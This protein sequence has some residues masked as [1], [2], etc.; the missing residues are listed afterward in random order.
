[1]Q[2][3]VKFKIISLNV[4]GIRDQTK[5]RSIFTYL[6]D[7]KANFYFVQEKY[8]DVNDESIWQ[9]EWGGKILFSHETH[10]SK[11]VCILLDPTIN[12]NV[13]YFFSNNTG[14]IVLITTHLNGVKTSL[15]NIYGPNNQSEQLEFIQELNNC[16]IDKS[17]MT[18]IIIGGDWNCTLTKKD[19]KGGAFSKPTPF[20]HLL[21]T[22]METF[23]LIDIYRARHPNL[24]L[25]SYESKSLQVKS[26]ID[27]FLVAKSLVKY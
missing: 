25:F 17:Q 7:Q 19:K 16:I 21:L 10:H 20:G 5:R 8:S 14:R 13:E 4:R 22:T 3:N 1:M 2:S 15:C 26:R 6:K 12:D 23:D 27:F 9:S 11:G 18:N 24:Q